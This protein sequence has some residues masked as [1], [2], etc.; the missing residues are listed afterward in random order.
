LLFNQEGWGD[1][2]K[3]LDTGGPEGTQSE[4]P[5]ILGGLAQ[6]LQ[7][8][9]R[10]TI[11]ALGQ[12][13][14][15]RLAALVESSDDAILSVDLDGTIATWNKSAERLYGYEAEEIIGQSVT[16]LIPEDRQEE[17]PKILGHVGRGEHVQHFETVRLRKDGRPIVVSLT[18]SPITDNS[19]TIIG[20]SKIARDITERKRVEAVLAKRADEQEA[21]Y[22]FTDR[23]FRATSRDDVY[24]AALDAIVRA[25]GCERASIL[26]FDEAGVMRFVAWRALSEGYCKAVEG[27][28]PWTR[29]TRDP[30][31]ITIDDI[32]AAE[33][34]PS[35]KA[36]VKAEGFGALAFI[37]LTARAELIGKFM[38]YY[39]VPHA[40]TD[41]EINIA[42]TI[43]RQLG[44]GL[45]RL[46]AEEQ[47]R[48]AEE[49]KELLLS[50]SKH[51][52]KNTL[53]TVQA[54]A[55][56]TLRH[57]RAGGLDS[58]LARLH[59]LGEAHELLTTENWDRAS[60]R[61][62]VERAIK[63]FQSGRG[64]FVIVGPA[65]WVPAQTSLTLT[66]CLHELATNAVKYGALSNGRGR[67]HVAWEPVV[68]GERRN[69]ILT[70]H[71]TG[72]PRVT[73]PKRKGFGSLLI[74]SSGDG[75]S[76]VDFH[77]D[78]VRCS[79]SLS[80]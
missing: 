38:A 24:D 9:V 52:I 55:S 48:K 51:R 72:G 45:E 35:L 42:I 76:R 25:L 32:E 15:Q 28:S 73:V 13:H 53:A 68:N 20:A 56:Q 59:A 70:W 36:T 23:L 75:D 80:L 2:G 44:F 16:L 66:L 60:L 29:N 37:P 74:E 21:L 41:T 65:V 22:Q 31:P 12:S 58:F 8:G 26:I 49:T 79:L 71:E 30:Q 43:A 34:D 27:H 40:F 50:E 47:R 1:V 4:R 19:G 18:V 62:L 11:E 14:A 10:A 64:R 39:P 33:L 61:E 46:S 7:D 77:S 17:E 69:V 63:P 78:G 6:R 57:G 3:S 5:G 54:I 67:V